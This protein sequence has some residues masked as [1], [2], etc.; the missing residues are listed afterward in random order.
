LTV[1]AALRELLPG[2]EIFY[3][4]DTARVPYGGKSPATIERYGIEIA[5]MLLAEGAKLIVVACNTA[6]ALATAPP[7]STGARAGSSDGKPASTL[8]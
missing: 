8:R 3:V 2:E 6:S 5:G 4:G 7:S 1:A